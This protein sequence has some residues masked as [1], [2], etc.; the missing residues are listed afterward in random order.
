MNTLFPFKTDV[1]TFFECVKWCEVEF[2]FW[3]Q[4]GLQHKFVLIWE[5]N[6][7]Q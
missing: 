2:Y 4:V 1:Y 3:Q 7:L 6:D 5:D